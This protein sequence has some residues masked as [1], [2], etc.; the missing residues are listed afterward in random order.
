MLDEK[1]G[2]KIKNWWGVQKI[3][4]WTKKEKGVGLSWVGFSI[5]WPL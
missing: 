1:R 5:L 4:N 3:W 2:V